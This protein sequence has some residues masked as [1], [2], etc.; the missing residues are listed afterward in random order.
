ME[1]GL[2]AGCPGGSERSEG[3][4]GGPGDRLVVRSGAAADPDRTDDQTVAAQRHRA[5]EAGAGLGWH[6]IP[7]PVTEVTG[8]PGMVHQTRRQRGGP[9]RAGTLDRDVGGP[10]PGIVHADVCH[11][12]ASVIYDSDVNRLTE[13][14]RIPFAG[15]DD[16]TGVLERYGHPRLSP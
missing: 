4:G 16:P 11:Q 3:G 6:D 13:V 5:G 2:S 12:N 1:A 10:Q 8:T 9:R 7:L 15:G 14:N